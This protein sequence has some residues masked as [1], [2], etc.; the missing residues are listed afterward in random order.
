[1]IIKRALEPLG[2][3]VAGAFFGFDCGFAGLTN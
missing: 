3:A 1:L 2:M